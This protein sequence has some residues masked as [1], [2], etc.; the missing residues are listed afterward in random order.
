M[1]NNV[2]QLFAEPAPVAE[3]SRFEELWKLW[4]NKAKKPLARAKYDAIVKGGFKTRTLDKDSG[5]FMEIELDRQRR[6]DT[7]GR[8][9]V[10]FSPD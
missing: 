8:Q 5:L 6:R 3:P 9:G 2:L 1:Q 4:P 10:P 7:G